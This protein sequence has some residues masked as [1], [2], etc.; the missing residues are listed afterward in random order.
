MP[1]DPRAPLEMKRCQ[2]CKANRASGVF[3]VV[4]KFFS[5]TKTQEMYL[6]AQCGFTKVVNRVR[7][8][9]PKD[10]QTPVC[11]KDV[12]SVNLLRSI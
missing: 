9:T 10:A 12:V 1:L 6:C 5:G 7:V 4:T 2:H 3:A 11:Y 8:F